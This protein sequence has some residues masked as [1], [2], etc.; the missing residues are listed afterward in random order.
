MA[1]RNFKDKVV[2][3]T[4]ACGGLG[5]ALCTS[6]G[7]EGAVVIATDIDSSGIEELC[8]ELQQSKINISGYTND[9]TDEEQV[10]K[11]AK[12]VIDKHQRIDVIINNA[13]ISHL[14]K[15][16]DTSGEVMRRV[17]NINLFGAMYWTS[18]C[19]DS[20]IENKGLVIALSSVAGFAPLHSRTM[21]SASKHAL[22]GCFE[23][24]RAEVEDDGVDV[25]M[26]CPAFI[27]TKID[28]NA[29]SGD[30]KPAQQ[31][32][33][34]AGKRMSPD[35]VANKIYVA[36]VKRKK[37]LLIGRISKMAYLVSR[38]SKNTYIA[39]MKKKFANELQS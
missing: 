33:L 6:F 21:Y 9:V 28:S 14:S 18:A 27:A 35:Y 7:R 25:L 34:H 37:T 22:H 20:I 19:I 15:F 3:I 5:K 12:E 10:R 2:V 11:I 29:L 1:K 13:G 26:V 36:S 31:N 38:F 39:A 16:S 4:G 32:R 23:S 30:G 8:N 17:I 24:L